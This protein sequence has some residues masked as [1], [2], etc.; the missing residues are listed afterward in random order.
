[1][2]GDIET[3]KKGIAAALGSSAFT[4]VLAAVNAEQGDGYT[5]PPPSVIYPY[6]RAVPE[7]YPAIELQGLTSTYNVDDDVKAVTHRIA[8]VVT[9]VGD[10]EQS[11]TTDIERLVRAIRDLL[12]RSVLDAQ[13]GLA[14]IL[15]ESENYSALTPN[16][17]T[18]ALVKGGMV[19]LSA[20]T[21]A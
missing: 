4:D 13:R 11:I 6:E 12:F 17:K 10:N 7:T 2:T 9:Q 3:V 14:P 15:I 1:M 19:V 21:F 8:V 5:T 20:T 18:G 16:P